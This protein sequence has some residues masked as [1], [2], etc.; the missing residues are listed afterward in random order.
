MSSFSAHR[1]A[2][3]SLAA[4]A[5]A[6]VPHAAM[7]KDGDNALAE[8]A[9]RNFAKCAVER[10]PSGAQALMAMDFNS[11]DY[12]KA[13]TRYARGNAN[14]ASGA[15]LKFG[16]ALFAG[17]LAEALVPD[18][19]HGASL[20][21]RIAAAPAA[22]QLPPRNESEAI[23]MCVVRAVPAAVAQVLATEP[24]TRAEIDALQQTGDALPKCVRT[25]M[26]V[27]FNRPMVRA[28]YALG[29]YRLL[30][31]PGAAPAAGN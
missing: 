11:P 22:A 15:K 4:A 29:A 9:L 20:E 7:A 30:T 23:G 31:D 5:L 8:Q 13:L 24:G 3:S 18:A 1:V 6:L 14:C 17:D 2:L 28:L 10:S 19:L 26:T 12:A 21:A 27:R 16:G 25:G